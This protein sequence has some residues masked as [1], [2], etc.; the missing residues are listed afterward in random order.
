MGG[1]PL[2]NHEFSTIRDYLLVSI[3]IQNGN[4]PCALEN[5]KVSRLKAAVLSPCGKKHVIL[6]SDHKTTLHQGLA[7]LTGDDTL[8][9]HL[10]LY[11]EHARSYVVPKN[12]HMAPL[13]D[14]SR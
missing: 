5:V 10:N 14:A 8:Y 7:N 4:R 3:H 9:R 6:V 13:A 2:S 12:F 1:H 11:V